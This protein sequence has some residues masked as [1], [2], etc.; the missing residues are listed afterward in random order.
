M[1]K[2]LLTTLLFTLICSVK[3]IAQNDAGGMKA[4][5]DYMTPGDVHKMIAKYDGKWKE[6]VTMW[7]QPG[8]P[9]TT[10]MATAVNEMIMG[11]RYLQSKTTG[12]MHGMPFE[13]LSLLGYDNIKKVFTSTWIDNFGTG[14][15]TL[16][17]TWNASNKTIN[18]NGKMMDPMSGK[19]NSV[20]ETLQLTDDNSEK[21]Q[22]FIESPKGEFKMMEINYTRI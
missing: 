1:K 14:T 17:G 21:F 4:W 8:A 10:N 7:M 6:Q 12:D 20:K 9:P 15:M 13:G 5:Q 18:F 19:E 2:I 22:M 3:V 11:G 16:E